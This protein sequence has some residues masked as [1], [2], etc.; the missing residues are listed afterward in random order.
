ME[1]VTYTHA[2][3]NLAELMDKAEAD[4]VP[5]IITRARKQ[6]AVMVSLSEWNSMQ[7]TLHLLRSPRNAAVLLESIAQLERGE[8]VIRDLI[9]PDG[10]KPKAA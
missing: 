1:T 6:A 5:I 2:R 10:S 3:E 9:D 7:E 8:Y 4:R